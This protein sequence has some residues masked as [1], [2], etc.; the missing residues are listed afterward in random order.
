M[1]AETANKFYE[2]SKKHAA[3]K[4][5]ILDL[6]LAAMEDAIGEAYEQKTLQGAYFDLE[7]FRERQAHLIFEGVMSLSSHQIAEMSQP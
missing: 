3:D 4:I 5:T 6:A 1:D 2:D 7:E